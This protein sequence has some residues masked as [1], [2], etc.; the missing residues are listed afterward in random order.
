VEV[1]RADA[2]RLTPSMKIAME[3]LR[4]EQVVVLY[5]GTRRY[6][7]ADKIAAVPLASVAGDPEE[8]FPRLRGRARRSGSKRAAGRP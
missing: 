8:L 3:D 7:I 2:P 5:P 1:K 6:D 4:L